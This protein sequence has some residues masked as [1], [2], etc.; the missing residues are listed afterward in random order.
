M[1]TVIQGAGALGSIMSALLA[2]AGQQVILLA[3]GDRADYLRNQGVS[4]TGLVDT[5]VKVSIET[6]PKALPPADLFITTVKTYDTKSA[7]APLQGQQF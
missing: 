3:R 5:T 6:D 4:L 7:L 2:R 1:I